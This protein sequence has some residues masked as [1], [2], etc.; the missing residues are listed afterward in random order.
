MC[1]ASKTGCERKCKNIFGPVVVL[2]IIQPEAMKR[3]TV[4]NGYLNCPSGVLRIGVPEK[5]LEELPGFLE[6]HCI[7]KY[8]LTGLR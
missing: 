4:L 7:T 2:E 3:K 5:T 1:N 8:K 6:D